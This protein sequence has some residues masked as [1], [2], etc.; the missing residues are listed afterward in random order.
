MFHCT[1]ARRSQSTVQYYKCTYQCQ[2]PWR[3]GRGEGWGRPRGFWHFLEAR[4]FPTAGHIVNVRFPI[5][6]LKFLTQQTILDIKIPTLGMLHNV[7]FLWVAQQGG[8]GGGGAQTPPPPPPPT[9][10]ALKIVRCIKQANSDWVRLMTPSLMFV[11]F[12]WLTTLSKGQ[13]TVKWM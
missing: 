10:L 8:G 13:I 2:A 5:S 9:T 11:W 12:H 6:R 4:K 3:W 7:K 1:K